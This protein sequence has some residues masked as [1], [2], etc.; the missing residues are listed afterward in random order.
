[1]EG[2]LGYMRLLGKGRWVAT[3]LAQAGRLPPSFR[4]FSTRSDRSRDSVAYNEPERVRWTVE[5]ECLM[6]E[7]QADERA[8]LGD[9][10]QHTT[11]RRDRQQEIGAYEQ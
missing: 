11:A 8:L 3:I 7:H 6:E 5:D 1:M 4:I 10:E 9:R 2:I